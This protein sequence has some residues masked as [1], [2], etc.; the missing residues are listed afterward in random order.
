LSEEDFV[1]AR[2]VFAAG[3]ETSVFL[4]G[5]EELDEDD[6]ADAPL[7]ELSLVEPS[8]FAAPEERA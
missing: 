6:G 4:E 5:S 8:D 3:S 7:A 2:E 1:G